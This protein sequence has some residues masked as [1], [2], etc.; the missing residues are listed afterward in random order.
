MLNYT[1]IWFCRFPSPPRV[2]I[3][4]AS[5]CLLFSVTCVDLNQNRCE[6]GTCRSGEEKHLRSVRS[7]DSTATSSSN[8]TDITSN[9]DFRS[10]PGLFLTEPWD[11]LLDRD[12]LTVCSCQEFVFT[13]RTTA[14]AERIRQVFIPEHVLQL[15][16]FNSFSSVVLC[17]DTPSYFVC[18]L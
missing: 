11:E 8:Q 7:G 1:M 18:L 16:P 17:R 3:V 15:L 9:P 13:W 10:D 4:V 5:C 2:R 6:G 12:V 14:G